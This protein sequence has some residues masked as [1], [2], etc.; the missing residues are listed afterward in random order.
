MVI[1]VAIALT[2][3]AVS[4]KPFQ[5]YNIKVEKMRNILTSVHIETTV[6][7]AEKLFETY[8][9]DSYVV[10]F[11]GELVKDVKAFDLD[12]FY[13]LK[14][15]EKNPEDMLLP[16]FICSKDQKTLYIFPARGKGLWGPIWGYIS[17]NEDFNTIYGTMFDHKAETPGLGAEISTLEFQLQFDQ[18]LIFDEEGKLV[19]IKTVKGGTSPDDPHGVD[20]ISGGTITSK[21]LEKMLLDCLSLYEPYLLKNK[22]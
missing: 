15:Q 17:L 19:S 21:G 13:E 5:E 22:K 20:A 4:L 18:K 3:A 1:V 6:D 12:L 8:I 7:D 2:L 16:V 9:T 10:N 14:K 11:K